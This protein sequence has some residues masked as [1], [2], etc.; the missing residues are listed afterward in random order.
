MIIT[1]TKD[2][3]ISS[4][5]INIVDTSSTD[6]STV[7]TSGNT[8]NT[9][10][11]DNADNTDTELLSQIPKFDKPNTI[12]IGGTEN[13]IDYHIDYILPEDEKLINI[14]KVINQVDKYIE[15]YNSPQMKTYNQA[16]KQLLQKYSNKKY[17]IKTIK[18]KNDSIKI[19]VI[20]NDKTNDKANDKADDKADDNI[21]Y[22]KKNIVKEITKP[23]YLF[24]DEDFNLY[25]LKNKI[26]NMR[27][28]LQY[29]YEILTSKLNITNDEKSYFEKD[30][31]KLIELLEEYYI[32]ILYHKK[33]NKINTNNKTSLLIQEIAGFYKENIDIN[34]PVLNSN[35]YNIDNANIDI[36]NK[37]NID[38]LTQ[39]NN[40][41]LQLSGKDSNKIKKDKK[42]MDEIKNYLD[43]KEI[44]IIT[45]SIKTSTIQQNEDNIINYIIVNLP[46]V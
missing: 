45:E 22:D 46:I 43:K 14:E 10:N 21:I 30:R 38:K 11:T 29:K 27:S 16:F 4:K 17:I 33:I 36:I 3:D 19:I 37:I 24:Y 42:L 39:F 8:D 26:S 18:N 35:L 25:K 20:K 28:E 32:Y 40:L 34:T 15:N 23:M 41:M 31:K 9:D 2:T 12:L 1:E 6:S 5:D 13:N 44:N 7:D